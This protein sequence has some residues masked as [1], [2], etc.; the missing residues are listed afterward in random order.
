[1]KEMQDMQAQRTNPPSWDSENNSGQA[2]ELLPKRVLHEMASE[3]GPT[4]MTEL[5][6]S[7]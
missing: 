1:M 4:G 2:H 6:S 5:P 7:R 3:T